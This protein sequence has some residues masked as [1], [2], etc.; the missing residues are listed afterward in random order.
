LDPLPKKF[1]ALSQ[2]QFGPSF[3]FLAFFQNFVGPSSQ[4]QKTICALRPK[5]KK[6]IGLIHFKPFIPISIY[7][8]I[9]VTPH[10]QIQKKYK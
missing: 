6:K 1:I 2:K 3:Q 10:T 4:F 8:Q 5:K 7:T 9:Q